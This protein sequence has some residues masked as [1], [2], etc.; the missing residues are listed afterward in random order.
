M[1]LVCNFFIVFWSLIDIPKIVIEIQS[2]LEKIWTW[3]YKCKKEECKINL[4]IEDIFTGSYNKSDYECIWDFW[5]G[6][7][8]T[9]WTDEKCNPWYVSYGTWEHDLNIKVYDENNT[10]NFNQEHFK[11]INL[12][13]YEYIIEDENFGSW[14]VDDS[15]NWDENNSWNS[16]VLID[17]TLIAIPEIEIEIQSWLEEIWTWMY[18]CK[19]EECKINLNVEDIFIWD[20]NKNDYECLWDFWWWIFSTFWTEEKCNPWFINYWTWE[21]ELNIKVYEE[22]NFGNF[23]QKYFSIL[24]I[25]DTETIIE[26]SWNSWNSSNNNWSEENNS[27][28]SNILDS[29]GNTNSW[30]LID[31]S[32]EVLLVETPDIIWSFQ[33]PSYIL[34]SDLILEKYLCDNSKNECKINL[35]LRDSFT[36]SFKESDFLCEIDFWF[37]TWN[38]TGEE[39]KCNPNTIIYWN[40]V[41]NLNFKITSEDYSDFYSTWSFILENNEIEYNSSINNEWSVIKDESEDENLNISL[42]DSLS[43]SDTSNSDFSKQDIV[44]SNIIVQSWLLLD[45]NNNYYCSKEVCSVNL[46]YENDNKNILCEWDFWN[47]IFSTSW[48]NKKCNPWYVK[49]SFWNHEIN[50]KIYDK[51][52]TENFKNINFTFENSLTKKENIVEDIILDDISEFDYNI[53]WSIKL[54][55]ISVNPHWID[56]LEYIELLNNSDNI[57][58]LKWCYLDDILLKW[59]KKYVFEDDYFIFPNSQKKIYKT[60]TKLNLTNTWDEVN[61]ICWN[62]IIDKIGWNFSVKS[63]YLINHNNTEI[64][65][66]NVKVINVIDWDTIIVKFENWHLEKIRLIWVDTPEIKDPRKPVQFFWFQASNYT[67]DNLLG[68]EVFLEIDNSNYRDKYSRLLW[69]VYLD[70]NSFNN[71]LIKNWYSRF[72]WDFPFKYSIDYKNSEIYSKT[73][74]LWM[75]KFINSDLENKLFEKYNKEIKQDEEFLKLEKLVEKDLEILEEKNELNNQYSELIDYI[76]LIY[77]NNNLTESIN[78][79]PWEFVEYKKTN[80]IEKNFLYKILN[81]LHL[82]NVSNNYIKNKL[83]EYK[84]SWE[85][86]FLL[87]EKK[88]IKNYSSFVQNWFSINV[89]KLKSWL[90]IYWKTIKN[91]HILIEYWKNTHN[92]ISDNY[93][94]FEF[95]I[96]DF[97]KIKSWNFEIKTEVVDEFWNKFKIDK[98]KLF[99]IDINYTI[100]LKLYFFEKQILDENQTYNYL[101]KNLLSLEKDYE[102]IIKKEQKELLKQLKAKLNSKKKKTKS[103]KKSQS[104]NSSNIK[105][106][107][108]EKISKV[109]FYKKDE[110][111]NTEN[112]NRN[113]IYYYFLIIIF[114][115]ILIFI[116]L[117][118]EKVI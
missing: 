59:S 7:F 101:D 97:N 114:S 17:D 40:W 1:F 110:L 106:T 89:S 105:K 31:D 93:W 60:E 54:W 23:K 32:E 34:N 44:L 65:S 70:W 69:Y 64:K 38:F 100:D 3:I 62:K 115:F 84:I 39:N 2:G 49:Y 103:S 20:Y 76:D 109:E 116:L 12:S 41:Y 113:W 45:F 73:N 108:W 71:D 58:N 52:Y 87:N 33:N 46:N 22:N 72:Y 94:N 6:T 112:N 98:L 35:D 8:T 55:N 14:N 37:W 90:K 48:T 99:N 10:W 16:E 102:K 88:S 92:L 53:L 26:D 56:N 5:Y 67:K 85:D 28:E 86:I 42:D 95:K 91:S 36:W 24:N 104:N 79:I 80:F 15:V 81:K 61:L 107:L 66:S 96:N 111:W 77:L 25:I 47:W 27:S 21:F 43:K 11:I 118:R 74:K 30:N 63:W 68:K 13:D 18:K 9:N 83:S 29:W 82:S 75:W 19:K 57:I 117:K 78:W 51:N 4:N 50:L